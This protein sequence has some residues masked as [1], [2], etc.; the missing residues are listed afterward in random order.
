MV[1]LATGSIAIVEMK[2]TGKARHAGSA[3]W[4]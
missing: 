1:R 2:V 4:T 3:I